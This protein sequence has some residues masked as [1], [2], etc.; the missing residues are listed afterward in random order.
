MMVPTQWDNEGKPIAYRQ[1]SSKD[2]KN[3]ADNIS[4][5]MTTMIEGLNT[6]YNNNQE[7]FSG[8]GWLG[9]GDS[10][11]SKV[12]KTLGNLGSNIGDITDSVIKIATGLVPISWNSEGKP[13]KFKQLKPAD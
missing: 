13:T 3:A 10:P 11:A 4:Y 7:I 5:I 2:F 6:C 12:I 9:L 8:T 1:L